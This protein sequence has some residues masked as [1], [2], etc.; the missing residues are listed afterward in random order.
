MSWFGV[1]RGKDELS[2]SDTI[3]LDD[4]LYL[5]ILDT[6]A[7]KVSKVCSI[8]LSVKEVK[9]LRKHLG[10]VLKNHAEATATEA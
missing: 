1:E 3:D 5:E 8:Y 6:R 2:V 7:S 9:K 10:K 4:E